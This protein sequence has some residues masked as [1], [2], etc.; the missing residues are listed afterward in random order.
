MRNA[1]LDEAQAGIKIAGRNINN[2]RYVD[3][4]TLMAEIE[5]KLK[6]LLLKVKESEKV[7]LK[8]NIQKTKFMTSGPITSWQIDGETVETV[9]E[10]IF[11]GSKIT[12]GGDFSHEIKRR[13]FLGRKVITNL[14]SILQS[15]NITLS[16]KVCLVKAMVFPVVK[17]G[18]ESW[19]IKKAEHQRTDAFELWC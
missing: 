5:E 16:T 6:S 2:L 12:A 19:N 13:L 3:D 9:T 4:T 17:C 10:F 11:W 18:C 8:L 15:R 7:G 14:D 1:G